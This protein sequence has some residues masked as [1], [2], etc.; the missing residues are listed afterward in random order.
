LFN[1][2]SGFWDVRARPLFAVYLN[3][4][5]R[6]SIITQELDRHDQMP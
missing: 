1:Q 2:G 5:R 4:V 3:D 6:R